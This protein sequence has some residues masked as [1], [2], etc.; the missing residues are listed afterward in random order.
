MEKN[1][2]DKTTIDNNNLPRTP[3]N[4]T[5]NN[6]ASVRINGDVQVSVTEMHASVKSTSTFHRYFPYL[7]P[8]EPNPCGAG[9][10]CENDFGN[11]LCSCPIGTRGEPLVRCSK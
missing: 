10:T 11:A 9:A 2:I 5:K 4:T 6:L 8:C 7:D 1:L 3:T